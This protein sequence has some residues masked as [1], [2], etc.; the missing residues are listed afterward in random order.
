MPKLLEQVRT[1]IRLR[2]YSLRTDFS[3][4]SV[5]FVVNSYQRGNSTT[6]DTEST[7]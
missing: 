7:E 1:V 3:V 5:S 2:H 6:E 4:F